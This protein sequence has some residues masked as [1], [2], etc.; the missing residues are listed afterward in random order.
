MKL[1]DNIEN[2]EQARG[3]VAKVDVDKI[4]EKATTVK[5]SIPKKPVVTASAVTEENLEKL[6]PEWKAKYG[7]VFKNTIDDDTYEIWR[8][9]KRGEYKALLH[10]REKEEETEDRDGVFLRQEET[11]NIA[12]LY[13]ANAAELIDSRAGLAT[14]LSEEILRFSGFEISETKSL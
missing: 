1:N 10:E 8:P 5:P 9:L 12:I 13:P 6:I 4:V 11:C 14:V 3:A 2:K 7:K